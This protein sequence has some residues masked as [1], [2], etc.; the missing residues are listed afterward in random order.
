[1][2]L[3][4]EEEEIVPLRAPRGRVPPVTHV[5]ST[6]ISA[7]ITAMRARGRYEEYLAR[8]P[9]V[10]HE[11]VVHMVAGVW[12]PIDVAVAHYETVEHLGF[13]PHDALDIGLEVA[14]VVRASALGGIVR[15]VNERGLYAF[16]VTNQA[17]VAK[18]YYTEA[19]VHALHAHIQ[20]E[21]NASGAHIDAFRY[22][23][24]HI[25]GTVAAYARD[26]DWRKPAPGML[27][28]LMREWP[29][30]PARSLLIGDNDSDLVAARAAGI[31]GKKYTSG[32]LRTFVASA[33]DEIAG[34]ST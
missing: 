14:A 19:E 17:G 5:R 7:S 11:T 15:L 2:P 6:L 25:D 30:D 34:A 1:M 32:G 3:P 18:G 22:C 16:V 21:L 4:P 26:S 28:D 33:L 10:H 9:R 8:L 13:T 23:P 12:V 20:A 31:A 27:L 29:V 24:Y